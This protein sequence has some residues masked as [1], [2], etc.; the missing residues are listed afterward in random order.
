MSSRRGHLRRFAASLI[1]WAIGML[2]ILVVFDE[3]DRQDD[4]PVVLLGGL[5]FVTVQAV[6]LHWRRRA[7]ER[8]TA[9]VLLAGLGFQL[10]YPQ[11]VVPF[12]GLYVIGSLAAQ[13]PRSISG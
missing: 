13:R 1:P 12:V 9:V 4:P 7:P 6:A 8:V 5:L 10:L 11:V 2:L 3:A